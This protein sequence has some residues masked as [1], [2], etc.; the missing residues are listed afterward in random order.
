MLIIRKVLDRALQK[1][2]CEG[3]GVRYLENAMAYYAVE[4]DD[5]EVSD[6]LR[7]AYEFAIVDYINSSLE[8]VYGEEDC[9]HYIGGRNAYSI[10][11]FDTINTP[12]SLVKIIAVSARLAASDR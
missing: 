9:L 4:S 2:L 5:A 11:Y 7:T 8:Y 1:D 12:D 6:I 3:C 10:N